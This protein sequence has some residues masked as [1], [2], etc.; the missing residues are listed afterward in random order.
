MGSDTAISPACTF[1]SA[2]MADQWPHVASSEPWSA[3]F[4]QQASS[5]KH[6]PPQAKYIDELNCIVS[7][8]YPTSC[9]LPRTVSGF[10]SL[11][12]KKK[13]T[14]THLEH[15]HAFVP[16]SRICPA[17]MPAIELL[18]LFYCH[19]SSVEFPEGHSVPGF[20]DG[21]IMYHTAARPHR[22]NSDWGCGGS[23]HLDGAFQYRTQRH[24][25]FAAAD[26]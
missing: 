2:I 5:L 3:W 10:I 19:S 4:M 14:I 12:Q 7:S 15:N 17:N 18:L 9:I 16:Q 13:R 25:G 22:C 6:E 8:T 23:R 26:L 1:E 20:N 24:G 11:S 21:A